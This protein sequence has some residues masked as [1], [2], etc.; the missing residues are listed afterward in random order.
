MAGYLVAH[1][2]V[3]DPQ[4]FEA[5]RD[6]VPAV[7]ERFGGRYHIR[8]G[9]ADVKEGNWDVP[10]LVVIEFPSVARAQEFYDSPEYQEILPLRLNASTGSLALVEGG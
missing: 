1:I 8:G 6:A 5:Y 9:K 7:I 3:T 10:R 2:Q 4:G